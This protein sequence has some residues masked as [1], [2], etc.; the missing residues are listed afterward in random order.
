MNTTEGYFQSGDTRLYYQER[1]SG[2]PLILLMG[3]G[4]DGNVWELHAAE[5]E[6]HFR[7]IIPDNRGVGRS[8]AP[9]GPYTTQMMAQDTANLNG[10]SRC[11]S[12]ACRR[13][14]YGRSHCTGIGVKPSR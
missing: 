2:E 6:K 9:P 4:A 1:G 11:V 8:D 12:G 13:H 10:S 5:Y 14:F 7:C 3:F